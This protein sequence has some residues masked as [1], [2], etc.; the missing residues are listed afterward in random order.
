MIEPCEGRNQWAMG[1]R[2]R[3]NNSLLLADYYCPLF[4]SNALEIGQTTRLIHKLPIVYGLVQIVLLPR[5]FQKPYFGSWNTASDIFAKEYNAIAV[6]VGKHLGGYG[7]AS[8]E[9]VT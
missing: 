4:Q 2:Q 3:A 8:R 1:N 5:R 9:L 7:A 6:I